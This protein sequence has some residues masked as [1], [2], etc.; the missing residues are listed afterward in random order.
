MSEAANPTQA[1]ASRPS[2]GWYVAEAPDGERSC[3]FVLWFYE[4]TYVSENG[5]E[6]GVP[7]YA[8]K[9]KLVAK[10]DLSTVGTPVD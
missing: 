3:V 9:K 10:L 2:Q 1:D 6:G 7:F 4:Q 5:S 8:F